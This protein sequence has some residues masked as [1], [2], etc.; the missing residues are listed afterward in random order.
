MFEV[1]KAKGWKTHWKKCK[2]VWR[3]VSKGRMLREDS[4]E[5]NEGQILRNLIN[6]S[7]LNIDEREIDVS[8]VFIHALI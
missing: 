8:P 2:K 4:G 5:I 7:I 3:E 1:L 6:C